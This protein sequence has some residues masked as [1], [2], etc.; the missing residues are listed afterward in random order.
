MVGKVG[1]ATSGVNPNV[2]GWR[3][4]AALP[5]LGETLSKRIVAYRQAQRASRGDP[6]ASVFRSLEDLQAVKGIG[7]KRAAALSKLVFFSD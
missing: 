3:E 2:A 1:Q 7:P 6:D 4:L 5:G